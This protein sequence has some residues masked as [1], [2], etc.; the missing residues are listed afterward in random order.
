MEQQSYTLY[1]MKSNKNLY[2]GKLY[3]F[4]AMGVHGKDIENVQ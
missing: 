3:C 4:A 2:K 1:N